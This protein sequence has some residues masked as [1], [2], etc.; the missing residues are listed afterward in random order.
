MTPEQKSAVL[1]LV[2]GKIDDAAFCEIYG[3]QAGDLANEVLRV[4]KQAQ[5]TRDPEAVET[6]LLL[7]ARFTV[8]AAA[9]HP[10]HE[11]LDQTWH[12]SHETMVGQLQQWRDPASVSR[13]A[14]AIQLKPQ[15]GYLDY[16]DYGAFYKKCLW[17]LAEIGTEEAVSVMREC[18]ASDDAV[19]REQAAYRLQKLAGHD[20]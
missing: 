10:I 9:I 8:P 13:L 3:I 6:A 18:A 11:L 19:L 16:D 5:A 7:G 1:D 4:L 2:T 14:R 12:W 20:P 15:L 17:A